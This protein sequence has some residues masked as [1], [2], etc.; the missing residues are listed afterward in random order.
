MLPFTATTD[1]AALDGDDETDRIASLLQTVDQVVA[2][3][4]DHG[5]GDLVDN[6]AG[7][8][9]GTLQAIPNPAALPLSASDLRNDLVANTVP[10]IRNDLAGLAA[11]VNA[12]LAALKFGAP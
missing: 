4:T 7:V 5:V 11:K 10:A 3:I 8:A 2:H 6:T 1:P 12:L 9:D